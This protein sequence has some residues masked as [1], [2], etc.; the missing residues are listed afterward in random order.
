MH[1]DS[2][3]PTVALRRLANGYQV[4]QAIHVAATLG[5]A[6]LLRD[7]PRDSDDARR[8]DRDPCAVAAPRAARAGQRRRAARGR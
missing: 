2:E 3:L 1:D 6:D 8:G 5:I 4:T 7:G